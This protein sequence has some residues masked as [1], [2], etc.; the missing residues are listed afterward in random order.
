MRASNWADV[1][2]N[3]KELRRIQKRP[4]QNPPYKENYITN[5]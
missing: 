1:K 2:N 3:A 4:K 5:S